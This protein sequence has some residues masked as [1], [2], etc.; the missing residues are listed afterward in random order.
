MNNRSLQDSYNIL[1]RIYRDGAFANEEMKSVTSK[2][3][4]KIVYGVLDKHF[5]LNYI[6]DELTDKIKPVIRPLLLAGAYSLIYLDTPLNVVLNET[7]AILDDAG[8]GGVKK[9]CYAVLS[10]INRREYSLP[11]KGDKNYVEVKYNLPAYLVGMF[12]KDYPDDY[13]RIISV[14]ESPKIHIVPNI[15]VE[16][17]TVLEGDAYAEK[18][19]TGYFVGNNKNISYLNFTGKITIMSYPSSLAAESVARSGRPGKKVLDVCAAPGGKSVYLALRGYEVT[20][21]D[22]YRHR[23]DLIEA[24]AKRMQASLVTELRD[25]TEFCEEYAEKYDV[26]FVDAPCS[27]LGVLTRRKDVVLNRT[28]DDIVALS[29]LQS[30]IIDN[31]CRYVKKGGLLVYSTCTVFDMENG[32]VV[33]KFLSEHSDFSLTKINLPYNNEGEI[34]FLPDGN[35]ME[36]FYLCHLAKN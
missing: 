17:K 28:Y 7:G 31:A 34:Q 18:T 8:K 27:G 32:A 2:R 6:L 23:L 14:R 9:F 5:E 15:G 29:R 25:G 22:I 24:Y 1:L 33:R 11:Q 16:E 20:G 10:K 13:E 36:G 12:K 26:V 30:K 3:V 19:L 21:C 4:T 35:G